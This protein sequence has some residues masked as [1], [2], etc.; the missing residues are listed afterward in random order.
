MHP[1]AADPPV[2]IQPWRSST[3]AMFPL[4]IWGGDTRSPHV[5]PRSRE[6]K[7]RGLS[8]N[9]HTTPLPPAATK[10]LLGRGTGVPLAPA[11]GSA[12]DE[13]ADGLG[14]GCVGTATIVDVGTRVGAGLSAGV[15]GAHA[16]PINAMEIN[17][18]RMEMSIPV[19]CASGVCSA[20]NNAYGRTSSY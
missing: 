17:Q 6:R 1:V 18:R 15:V 20:T 8:T 10:A 7:R 9:S 12:C 19:S 5:S 2:S 4:M 13:A 3:N 11:D 14:A 16:E